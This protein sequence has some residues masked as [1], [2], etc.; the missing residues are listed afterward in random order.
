TLGYVKPSLEKAYHMVSPSLSDGGYYL[1][2]TEKS[3]IQG[4]IGVGHSYDFYT[5]EMVG[6][7]TELYVLQAY[8]T[9]GIAEKLCKEALKQLKD[10]GYKNVQLNVFN[11]NGAKHLYEKLGFSD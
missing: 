9:Q 5:D 6:V 8:R 4:W 3:V 10:S 7:I 11:G 1:V 2:H